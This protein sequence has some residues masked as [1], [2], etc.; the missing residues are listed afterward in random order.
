MFSKIIFLRNIKLLTDYM[1]SCFLQLAFLY[2][3]LKVL[4][5]SGIKYN[6]NRHILRV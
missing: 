6:F 4:R 3:V 2:G 5:N 1:M